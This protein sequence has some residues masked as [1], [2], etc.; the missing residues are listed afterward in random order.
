M[1]IRS[2]PILFGVLEARFQH[3]IHKVIDLTVVEA[4]LYLVEIERKILRRD[5]MKDANYTALKQA[6][7]IL[8]TISMNRLIVFIGD[9]LL[10]VINR[11]V[12]K[13]RKYQTTDKS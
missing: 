4:K 3:P 9:L 6:P 13:T 5:F 12:S 2:R 11:T 8:A 10:T 1:S 7:N